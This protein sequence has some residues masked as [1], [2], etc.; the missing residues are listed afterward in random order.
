[1]YFEGGFLIS[2]YGSY[3]IAVLTKRINRKIEEY[4][5]VKSR[6]PLRRCRFDP[7]QASIVNVQ[8]GGGS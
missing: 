3:A 4:L 8:P 7:E 6:S 5:V 1:M 2:L